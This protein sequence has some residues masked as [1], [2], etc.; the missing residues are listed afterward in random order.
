MTPP[1]LVEEE[2][3]VGGTIFQKLKFKIQ[4]K[5]YFAQSL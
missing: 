1:K 2:A 4:N 3:A 5:N